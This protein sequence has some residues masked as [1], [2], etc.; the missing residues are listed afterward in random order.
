MVYYMTTC[1]ECGKIDYVMM[2]EQQH[3]E[4]KATKGRFSGKHKGPFKGIYDIFPEKTPDERELLIT[5]LCGECWDKLFGD[6]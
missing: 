5:G 6:E 1:P 2:T 4:L 3:Q